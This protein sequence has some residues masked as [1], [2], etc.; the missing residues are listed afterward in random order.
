MQKHA[1]TLTV[2]N[3]FQTIYTTPCADYS[4]SRY[5]PLLM[6]HGFSDERIHSIMLFCPVRLHT[7]ITYFTPPSGSLSSSLS[8]YNINC[9]KLKKIT[10]VLLTCWPYHFLFRP[11]DILNTYS[12]PWLDMA[13]TCSTCKSTHTL[14]VSNGFQTN[15]TPLQIIPLLEQH[16]S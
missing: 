3:G 8:D 6:L 12:W 10:T 1:H 14:T 9:A 16:Q 5:T 7:F 4:T 2:S 15:T 13:I 11:C